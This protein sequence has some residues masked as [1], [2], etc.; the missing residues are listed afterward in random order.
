LDQSLVS[1]EEEIGERQTGVAKAGILRREPTRMLIEAEAQKPAVLVLS[2][3]FYL[4]W[5]AKVDGV[6][7][8]LLRVNYGLR[9]VA[10]PA[11]KHQVELSYRPKSLV[12]GAAVSITTALCLLLILLGEK[13]RASVKGAGAA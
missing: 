3:I 9:G 11:G 2:E 7:A 5:R 1:R 13:R 8:E 4:G 6:E 12:T 10:L